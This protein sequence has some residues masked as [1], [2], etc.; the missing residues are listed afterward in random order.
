MR[1]SG[2]LL[3]AAAILTLTLP[4]GP[5]AVLAESS[6]SKRRLEVVETVRLNLP[7]GA[8]SVKLW[9]P[10][11]ANTTHQK[12]RLVELES[13]WTHRITKD[14]DYGNE[15]VFLES[16]SPS[17]G[18]IEFSLR[19]NVSRQEQRSSLT[20]G[21]V[22]AWDK[23]PRGL[24]AVTDEIRQ[25]ARETTTGL[26][27]PLEKA[28][29]LYH[30][31]FSRMDY[32]KTG[33]GWGRGDAA[34]ACK[35]R[36]GNCTDFHSLFAALAMAEGIPARFRIGFSL[37]SAAEGELGSGYHCWAEFHV[38]GMGWIPVDI[39]EAWKN[40][41]RAF[42]YF[43]NLDKDRVLVSTGREIQLN[44]RQSGEPLNYMVRPYAEADGKPLI[45]LEVSRRYK[46]LSARKPT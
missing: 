39:S 41:R 12:A 15:I 28:R 35:T 27:D 1:T 34:L 8:Q 23:E 25:I 42:Y 37:P 16:Q 38:R 26:E 36:K 4:F 6:G 20:E 5:P 14:P 32:D 43:G 30:Y 7:A 21:G 46:N 17:A 10:K 45:D 22:T 40:P 31:V 11:L 33:N 29:A 44:P 3:H 2:Y 9:I 24:T 19:Y 13:S 18:P